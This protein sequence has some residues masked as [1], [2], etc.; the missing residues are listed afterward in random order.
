MTTSA[1]NQLYALDEIAL[2]LAQPCQRTAVYHT[3]EDV[4]QRLIGHRL[5]TLLAVLPG[6]H[7][8]QRF[9]SSNETVYPPSGRKCLDSTPWGEVVLKNKKA[10]LGRNAADIR[11]AF[12]D[13]ALIASLG[14]GSVINVPIVVRGQL[15]G[16]MN[17][18]HRENHFTVDDVTIAARVAPY[19]I[20]AFIEEV[21]TI[22]VS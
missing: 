19:L 2:T 14:L 8:V 9:W 16:T 6:G 11:W 7:R 17:L 5:F 18:L 20:P 12:A 21:K 22:E 4:M 15:L 3:V 1:E 13:H 10:W